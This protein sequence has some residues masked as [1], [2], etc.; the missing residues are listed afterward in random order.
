MAGSTHLGGDAGADR[1]I[2]RALDPGFEPAGMD[3]ERHRR[4]G[5]VAPAVWVYMSAVI[6]RPAARAARPGVASG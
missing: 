5:P 1:R 4:V 2:A 6:R 3:P